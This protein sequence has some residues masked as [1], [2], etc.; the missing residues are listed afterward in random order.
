M[1][2]QIHR[3]ARLPILS[4]AT[5]HGFFSTTTTTNTAPQVQ[6]FSQDYSMRVLLVI[7]ASI[8]A[9]VA[10]KQKK[11]R[12]TKEEESEFYGDD[13]LQQPQQQ[14]RTVPVDQP[15]Y[16]YHDGPPP[17]YDAKQ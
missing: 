16:N 15:A 14:H 10:Q 6:P 7:V 1:S 17:P 2:I 9:V 4:S 11:R 3:A 8:V 12:G 5:Y 13:E